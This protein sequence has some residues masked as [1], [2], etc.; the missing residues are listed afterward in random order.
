MT[1]PFL[2]DGASIVALEPTLHGGWWWWGVTFVFLALCCVVA[3]SLW[4]PVAG[5]LAHSEERTGVRASVTFIGLSGIA[6]PVR[7]LGLGAMQVPLGCST[8]AIL[9]S[10]AIPASS[11]PDTRHRAEE[12]R[13]SVS[14][15]RAVRDLSGVRDAVL[16]ELM[17]YADAELSR[18]TVAGAVRK[19]I[20]H[21]MRYGFPSLSRRYVPR[22]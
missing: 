8:H 1:I 12:A 2:C 22:R 14:A 9:V 3:A 11:E 19:A 13:D 5:P 10:A 20:I 7:T 21:T 4:A 15:N 16:R 18:D 17:T 6:V